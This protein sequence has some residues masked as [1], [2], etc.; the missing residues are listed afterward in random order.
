MESDKSFRCK[1]FI[2]KTLKITME[3]KGFQEL[4]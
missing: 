1:A 2:L 3:I 4:V